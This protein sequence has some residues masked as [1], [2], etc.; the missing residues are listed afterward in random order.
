VKKNF[1]LIELL[2][3]IGIIVILAAMLLPSLGAAK[4]KARRT[5]CMNNL[6]QVGIA[7][8]GHA[9]ENGGQFPLDA[10][11]NAW[12]TASGPDATD[13]THFLYGNYE[14]LG[15][16]KIMWQCPSNPFWRIYVTY[17]PIGQ[18]IVHSY[19][20]HGLKAG[21]RPGSSWSEDWDAHP[22]VLSRANSTMLLFS[23]FVAVSTGGSLANKWRINHNKSGK[24]LDTVH[25]GWVGV[26]DCAGANQLFADGHAVWKN[27]IIVIPPQT[28]L[29]Q[30]NAFFA[31]GD[32]GNAH[33]FK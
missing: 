8:I 16:P 20:Y 22:T 12:N 27:K 32:G 1:T 17:P 6:R 29:P 23:D 3:V 7:T 21:R 28:G 19:P 5:T 9:G 4:E 33:Y 15:L 10:S 18:T 14:T 31:T 24:R 2:V 26:L 30:G 11:M 25:D 13:P